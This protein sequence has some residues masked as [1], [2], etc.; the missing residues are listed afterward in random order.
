[1]MLP[2]SRRE[3][4]RWGAALV[5]VVAAHG[6]GL[7]ALQNWV[8]AHPPEPQP[9][10]A[11][12]LDLPPPSPPPPPAPPPP[13]PPPPTPPPEPPPPTPPPPPP[14]P[15]KPEPPQPPPPPKPVAPKK[16]EPR[17]PQPVAVPNDAVPMPQ[18]PAPPPSPR[19]PVAQ[20]QDNWSGLVMA[21][22]ERFKRY[23]RSA[24]LRRDQGVVVLRFTVDREGL[25]LNADIVTSSNVTAL[26]E[27][28]LLLARRISPL[29]APP[30]EM[31]GAQISLTVPIKFE[32]R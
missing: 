10:A 14:E 15:P 17:P 27:E 8:A 28:A 30:P 13:E 20:M 3:L 2:S 21:R 12:L 5:A 1:M 9:Q 6:A 19:Q 29:P 24:L 4:L 23:P 25:V 32:L 18:P 16:I 22:I 11:M 7:R 26:D 31:R